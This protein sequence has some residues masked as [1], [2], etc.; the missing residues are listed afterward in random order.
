MVYD[1]DGLDLQ[2]TGLDLHFLSCAERTLNVEPSLARTL[3][4]AE[5]LTSVAYV[6]ARARLQPGSGATWTEMAGVHAMFDGVDSPLTQTFGLGVT[7]PVGP[8]ELNALEAFFLERESPVHHE[9]SRFCPRTILSLL[10]DRGYDVVEESVVLIRPTGSP[11]DPV[12]G[13]SVRT[14]EEGEEELWA[15]I[16]GE[17]WASESAELAEFVTGFGRLMSRAEGIHCFLAESGGEPIAAAALSI[18]GE[19]AVLA[20]ASTLPHARRRGAQQALL[21]ARL[22]F[23]RKRGSELAMVVA[24]PE[25]GS[26]RNAERQGFR[27]AYTRTKW[28]LGP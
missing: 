10:E 25:S 7:G 28:R 17:G 14:A 21:G 1:G 23:A 16:S 3:E 4:R 24:Q 19:M 22:R 8:G 18:R 2:A 11:P 9:V 6:E 26:L 5:A 20:G 13:L 27:Q 15:R 12:A